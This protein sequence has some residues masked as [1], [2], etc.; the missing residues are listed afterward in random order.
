M[1]K[2]KSLQ[3]SQQIPMLHDTQSLSIL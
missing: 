3:T 2:N 1:S